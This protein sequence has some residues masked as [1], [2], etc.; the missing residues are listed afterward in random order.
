MGEVG[1]ALDD[2]LLERL[3]LREVRNGRTVFHLDNPRC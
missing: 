3:E 2:E 1:L